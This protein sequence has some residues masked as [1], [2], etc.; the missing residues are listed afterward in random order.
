MELFETATLLESLEQVKKPTNFLS[1]RYFPTSKN[2]DVFKTNKVLIEYRKGARKV[3][4]FIS[5]RENGVAL[6]NYG[7][8]MREYTPPVIGMRK[9]MT[10]DDLNKRGFGE[11]LY[12]AM[13]PAE[14]EATLLVRDMADLRDVIKRRQ[15]VM[16]AEVLFNNALNIQ[17]YGEDG[18][19]GRSWQMK[20]YDGDTD[21]AV[22]TPTADWS[23]TKASGKQILADVAA[24]IKMLSKRGIPATEVLMAPD[25]ADV[26]LA[27]EYIH[28]LLDNRRIEL[29]QLKPMELPDGVSR[30]AT[31][32]IKGRNID[33]L[34]YDEEYYDDEEKTEKPYIPAGKIILLAPAC[35]HTVYGGITQMEKDESF[36]T[37]AG[38]AVPRHIVDIAGNTKMVSLRS[39]PL[40]LP[41]QE[42]PWVVAQVIKPAET[43][44]GEESGKGDQG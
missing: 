41:H 15:E 38:E 31:L 42:S 5:P 9:T 19:K 21:P 12:T 24:M 11:A 26:F 3:A 17:E 23:D 1:D 27:N 29:G 43:G 8:Y 4:P 44:K 37:Y 13:A 40:L 7:E 16:A 32:N 36:H 22:Y 20:F 18:K 28:E 33:F 30:I 10:I 25:V 2:T 39:A 6:E 34:T 35:G 14:R